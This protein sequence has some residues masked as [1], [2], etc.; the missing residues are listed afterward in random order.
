M[1]GEEPPDERRC[2][3]RCKN[4]RLEGAD[5][6]SDHRGLQSADKARWGSSSSRSKK[7]R[8]R[9]RPE[10]GPPGE[11]EKAER[12]KL[13]KKNEGQAF[14]SAGSAARA[15]ERDDTK[16]IPVRE[17]RRLIMLDESDSDEAE[18]A[19]VKEDDDDWKE[20]NVKAGNKRKIMHSDMQK[21]KNIKTEKEASITDKDGQGDGSSAARAKSSSEKS[22]ENENYPEVFPLS[23]P[24][25]Y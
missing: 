10:E 13:R 5:F 19:L 25:L 18:D 20:E 8:V 6:C 21:R 22:A 7:I 9:V 14:R 2:L 17:R 4:L 3:W 15:A 12:E 16:S 24:F 1:G 11:E 23:F